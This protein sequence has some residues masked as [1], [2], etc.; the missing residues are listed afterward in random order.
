MP[1]TLPRSAERP[2]ERCITIFTPLL[3]Q[4]ELR[5]DVLIVATPD[6]VSF[7]RAAGVVKPRTSA[8]NVIQ[9]RIPL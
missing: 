1:G 3:A 2:R 8:G 4:G 5:D 9:A 6:E 7:L